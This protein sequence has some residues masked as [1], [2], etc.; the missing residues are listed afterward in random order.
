MPPSARL[1][2]TA[3]ADVVKTHGED[4]AK[5]TGKFDEA[6][7]ERFYALNNGD[8]NSAN[9]QALRRGRQWLLDNKRLEVGDGKIALLKAA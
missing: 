1:W 6:H 7:R 9:R 2:T 4:V 8:S 3:Y 5:D